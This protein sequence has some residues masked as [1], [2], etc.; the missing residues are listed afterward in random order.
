LTGNTKRSAAKPA[1][2]KRTASSAPLQK[3]KAAEIVDQPVDDVPHS[4]GIGVDDR[5]NDRL[6]LQTGFR[7]ERTPTVNNSRDTT[8]ADANGYWIGAAASCQIRSWL[9]VDL[10]LAYVFEDPT[11]VDVES[12][13]RRP[14]SASTNPV[15]ASEL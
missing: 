3:E 10:G 9:G 13:S 14:T 2:S 4:A 6:T 11:T 7:F 15:D 5:G 1:G 8:F 12:S